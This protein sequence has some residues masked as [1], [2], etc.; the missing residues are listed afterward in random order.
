[1]EF[2]TGPEETLPVTDAKAR[3][4]FRL[5]YLYDLD[6]KTEGLE[7]L[8]KLFTLASAEG[9]AVLP[10]IPPVNYEFA[11]TLFGGT[12]DERYGSN[13]E[14]VRRLVETA[15]FHLL[16]MS[17]SLDAS[18]FST[19]TTV[20]ETSNGPGREKAADLLYTAIQ[21]MK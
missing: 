3:N 17:Y 9:I 1:M 21:E 14:K 19:P 12:F 16:D 7:Y 20:T 10:F 18:L 13:V 15:G 8:S 11:R 2:F 6:L 4:Y 5:N